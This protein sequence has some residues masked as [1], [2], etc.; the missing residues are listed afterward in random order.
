MDAPRYLSKRKHNAIRV[1]GTRLFLERGYA[2]VSMEQIATEAG[3]SKQTLYN[4][5]KNKENLFQSIIEDVTGT[6]INR[7]ATPDWRERNPHAVLR[8]FAHEFVTL[9]L[10]PASLGLHRIIVAEAS[11][12]PELAAG[13][14]AA[15]PARAIAFIADYLDGETR[16]GRLAVD[17]PSLAAEMFIGMLT[18]RLQLRLLIGA[19]DPPPPDEIDRRV[20]YAVDSF[21]R[22]VAPNGA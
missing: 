6:L 14:Y 10:Q 8:N 18:G 20:D 9:M 11:R 2:A 13:I 3:V 1:S 17:S 12:F 16:Q 22:L 5:F 7:I 15:G 4:H 19:G 21:L